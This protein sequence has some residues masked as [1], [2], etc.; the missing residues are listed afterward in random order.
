MATSRSHAR[1]GIAPRPCQRREREHS[2]AQATDWRARGFVGLACAGAER[3]RDVPPG[4]EEGRRCR[5]MED[6]AAR[7]SDDVDAS[8]S[9]RSRSVVT[10]ARAQAVRAARSRSSCHEDVRSRGEE[11]PELIGPEAT[12]ARPSDLEPVVEFRDPI[13]DVAACTVKLALNGF[14][15]RRRRFCFYR[16]RPLRELS[17]LARRA[18]RRTL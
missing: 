3:E 17:G 5:Q 9:S 16:N 2:S 11:H 10:C 14:V 4:I 18:R 1:G 8:V 15:R 13:F 7:R 12:A 6:D